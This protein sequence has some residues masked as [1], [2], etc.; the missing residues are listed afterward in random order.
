[1]SENSNIFIYLQINAFTRTWWS[2][3]WLKGSYDQFHYKYR[4]C[5]VILRGMFYQVSYSVILL[6]TPKVVHMSTNVAGN[7]QTFI[8]RKIHD[9]WS[10]S[11]FRYRP[12]SK[13]YWYSSCLLQN[14][15]DDARLLLT[16]WWGMIVPTVSQ[17]R[18]L[19]N[20]YTKTIISPHLHIQMC[21]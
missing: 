18:K 4:T 12:C 3:A 9:S 11:I 5:Y 20:W 10:H 17:L 6:I 16:F 1:M 21:S 2:Y 19:Q 14:G 13:S 15:C 7:L 8:I